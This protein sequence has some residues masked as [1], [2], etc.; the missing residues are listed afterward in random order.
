MIQQC[1]D[2]LAS[3]LIYYNSIRRRY[4]LTRSGIFAP[5]HSP[6]RHLYQNC[7]EGYFI[8]LTGFSG[9]TFEEMHDYLCPN[10][11]ERHDSGRPRLKCTTRRLP[12]LVVYLQQRR[13]EW[14]IFN[15]KVMR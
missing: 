14:H 6:L 1:I 8:N 12:D 4:H 11:L 15:Y 3:M 5:N 7:D 9:D 10:E 13:L 2:A